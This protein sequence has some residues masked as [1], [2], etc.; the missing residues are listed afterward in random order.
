[1]LPPH[2]A[3]LAWALSSTSAAL[4]TVGTPTAAATPAAIETPAA[5]APSE[6]AR[7][8]ESI[9]AE[10]VE[11][12]IPVLRTANL[13]MR[14][15]GLVQVHA[16]PFV[17][18]D[19]LIENGDPAAHGGFRLRRAR[20]GF[21]GR[22]REDFGIYLAVNPLESDEDVGTVSDAKLSYTFAPF[23]TVELGAGKVPFSRG[24][25]LSS[26]YLFSIERPLS[27][28][29]ITPSRRLGLSL[30]GSVLEGKIA[31]LA[32]LMNASEGFH[33]GNRY[34][35]LLVGGRVEIAPL[36]VPNVRAPLEEG[37]EGVS[38][39]ASGLREDG[40]SVRSLAGSV[41]LTLVWFGATAIF[42]GL[43]DRRTPIE[44]PIV[45]PEVAD[46]VNRCGLY[47]ELGYAFSIFDRVAQIAVRGELFD[48][49]TSLE[50]AG[51]VI[52]VS[53]GANVELYAPYARAQIH[54]LSRRERHGVERDN[55][56]LVISL[57]GSF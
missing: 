23:A 55:N 13:E 44:A 15:G 12:T 41:D 1:M 17:G 22:I 6:E 9:I 33:F 21:E 4:G 38:L 51:D 8:I 40:P 49:N 34:G 5:E 3:A 28:T 31:Y 27:V 50:D 30:E 52:L 32:A 19:A 14:I 48:D 57:Q 46:E 53:G 11:P 25:L 29:K 24:A 54:Y 42:E 10:D 16:A 36:G 47:A 2:G 39:G 35:G 26:R 7:A 37:A 43:C 18:S 45:A 20:F 56:A